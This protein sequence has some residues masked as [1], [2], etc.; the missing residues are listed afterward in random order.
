MPGAELRSG[1]VNPGPGTPG[2][3]VFSE[4]EGDPGTA[5]EGQVQG[6]LTT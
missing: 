5:A 4:P 3:G 2:S 1:E 6:Q